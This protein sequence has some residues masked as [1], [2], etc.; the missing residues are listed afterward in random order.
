MSDT[1]HRSALDETSGSLGAV[2][3]NRWLI[4][5]SDLH[6]SEGD[7]EDFD[8][9]LEAHFAA[10]LDSFSWRAEPTE[11][12]LNGDFL[13][14]VQASPVSGPDLERATQD[15]I[16]LCFT[17]SQ[18]LQKFGA[19]QR[20]HPRMFAALAEFLR[21][22]RENRIVILPGNHD[23][24]FF[25]PDVRAQLSAAVC[26]A[27]G[28]LS[29][30]LS[31]AY[32]PFPW[33]WIE[34]G[35]QHDPVNCFFVNGI[36]RW[37]EEHP[38]IFVEGLVGSGERDVSRLYECTGTRF[39]IRFLN[40]LDARYPY[41]DNVKPFSRFL[42][43]FGASALTPGWGPLD[44]SLTVASMVS[45]LAG[46][47]A[48]QRSD[49]MSMRRPEQPDHPLAAW[50]Q[51]STRSERQQLVQR[52]HDRGFS[53]EMPLDMFVG[54]P[55]D[56]ERLAAFLLEHLEVVEDFGEK[57]TALLGAS[58]GTLTLR[59]GYDANETEALYEAAASIA[60]REKV[61]TI[62]MGHTHEP[63][64]RTAA[65]AYINTGSWTRYLRYSD[66]DRTHP[67]RVLREKSYE[68]FP[69]RLMYAMVPP[70]GSAATVEVWRERLKT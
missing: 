52:L 7:L 8:Q 14:F 20:A 19:I 22:R 56:L 1:L 40:R 42:R 35:H 57:D 63:V 16:P 29:F 11:L 13:D 9:E 47:L 62:V 37:S 28:Q 32:R 64:E 31:R 30:C 55:A 24:D 33:L 58:S 50:L 59:D 43:I 18:S 60:S 3:A 69:Y 39:M 34:H 70:G 45:Y 6:A 61:T 49:L 67:W 53:V 2:S 38:P 68:R 4:V 54:R 17:Q 15:G 44:A 51:T 41:V 48:G 46:T 10:C 5:I 27:P 12:V 36:E 26:A 23:A 25:W 66:A 65:F 21:A